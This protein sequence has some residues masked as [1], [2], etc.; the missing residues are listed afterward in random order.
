MSTLRVATIEFEGSGFIKI[1]VGTT[2]QR[3]TGE[4]GMVRYNST[5]DEFEGYNASS[6][7]TISGGGGPTILPVLTRLGST[8]N[9]TVGNGLIAILTRT[10]ATVNVAVN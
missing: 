8:V 2:E 10:G 6:W 9:I 5:T 7:G 1:P 4:A 3:P